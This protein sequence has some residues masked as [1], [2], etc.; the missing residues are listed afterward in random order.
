M[1]E[2]AFMRI[3]KIE[4]ETTEKQRQM[5]QADSKPSQSTDLA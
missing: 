4:K 2:A 1:V 5:N 3:L